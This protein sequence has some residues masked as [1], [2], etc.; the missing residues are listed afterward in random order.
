M[1]YTNEG[2][3]KMARRESVTR[4]VIIDAAFSILREEGIE[5]VTARKL[6]EIGRAHV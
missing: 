3:G 4:D 5:Q 1:C 2:T 6:A